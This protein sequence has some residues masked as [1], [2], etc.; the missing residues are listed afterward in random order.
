MFWTAILRCTAEFQ[1]KFCDVTNKP[2]FLKPR[3]A[4]Q[5]RVAKALWMGRWRK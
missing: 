1:Q 2:A 5:T 3:V 4:T